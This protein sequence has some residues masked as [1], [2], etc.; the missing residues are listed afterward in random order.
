MQIPKS[1]VLL[2]DIETSPII[3]YVWTL[4]N[5]NSIK[6]IQNTRILCFAYKWLGSKKTEFIG[7][8]DFKSYDK[9]KTDDYGVAWHLRELLDEANIV[10]S[11]NGNAFDIKKILARVASHEIMPPSPF[12]SIDTL[13]VARKKFKFDSNRLDDLARELGVG[14]KLSHTGFAMWEG[15][16]AGDPD[17]WETMKSYNVTDVNILEKVYLRLR[18]WIEGHPN[19]GVFDVGTVCPNC[20]SEE[21]QQRGYKY[22]RTMR[23]KQ[24]VCKTCGAW[25]RSRISEK[26]NVTNLTN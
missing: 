3:S 13:M 18:P 20:G 2:I 26:P 17:C 12:Q 11:H 19:C 21:I 24:F 7:L 6:V 1:K 4:W 16:M 10:I 15:C 8:P 14:A 22:T 5:T 25:S 23:Y 9:D